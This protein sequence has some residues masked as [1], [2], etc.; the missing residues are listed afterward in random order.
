[1]VPG[2]L[3]VRD[4]ASMILDLVPDAPCTDDGVACALRSLVDYMVPLSLVFVAAVAIGTVGA[5]AFSVVSASLERR[6]GPAPA[7]RR[8]LSGPVHTDGTWVRLVEDETGRRLVEVLEGVNWKPS[9]RDL[10]QFLLDA[11]VTRQARG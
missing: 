8:L 5:L 11:S 6:R 7:R 9:T 2:P 3:L 4:F 10:S 1:M